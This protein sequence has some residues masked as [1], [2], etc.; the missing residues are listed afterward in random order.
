MVCT[1]ATTSPT[2]APN[3]VPEKKINTQV[4]LTIDWTDL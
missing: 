1:P 3:V 4:L 2:K